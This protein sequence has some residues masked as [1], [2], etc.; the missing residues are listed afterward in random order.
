MKYIQAMADEK[1]RNK[2]KATILPHHY[3]KLSLENK[4][5]AKPLAEI[6]VSTIT[7]RVS[8]FS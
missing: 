2:E 1:Q 3:N 6:M 7:E 5:S 4:L 8:Q